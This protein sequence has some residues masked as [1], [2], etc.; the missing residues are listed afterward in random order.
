MNEEIYC[1]T[2]GG[3]MAKDELENYDSEF[4]PALHSVYKKFG[5][6]FFHTYSLTCLKKYTSVLLKVVNIWRS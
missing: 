4:P 2:K 3:K 6:F 1:I 5:Q